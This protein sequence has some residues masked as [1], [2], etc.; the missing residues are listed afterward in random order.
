MLHPHARN[1]LAGMGIEIERR[2]LIREGQAALAGTAIAQWCHI[3]EGYFGRVNGL[4][5]RV[6]TIAWL[7]DQFEGANE[8]LVIA[9]VEHP[10]QLIEIPGWVGAEITLNRRYGV[11]TLARYPIAYP[12]GKAFGQ[13]RLGCSSVV[14][15]R[16]VTP[17]CT[18]AHVRSLS[19]SNCTT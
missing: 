1:V 4:R 19:Q 7:I 2:F 8:G 15:Q 14:D 12:P 13:M 6:R 5:V 11:S 9:E 18:N 17:N 16:S 3:R 10:R